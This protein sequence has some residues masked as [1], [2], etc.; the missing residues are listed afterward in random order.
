MGVTLR[1]SDDKSE[2]DLTYRGFFV[3]RMNVSKICNNKFSEYYLTLET[4]FRMKDSRLNQLAYEAMQTMVDKKE[5]DSSLAAFCMQSD[6]GGKITAEDCKSI[7]DR[8]VCCD[9]TRNYGYGEHFVGF[10]DFKELLEKCITTGCD[11]VWC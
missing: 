3:L 11:L 4:A 5:V 2:L 8:I 10:S 9:N 6:A 1:T 7:Y